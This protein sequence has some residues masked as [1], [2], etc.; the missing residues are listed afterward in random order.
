MDV[1]YIVE[2]N[3]DSVRV[4]AV[5]HRGHKGLMSEVS[6]DATLADIAQEFYE[7]LASIGGVEIEIVEG[8]GVRVQ[9]AKD[10]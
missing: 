4:Y 8:Y 5:N 6:Q 2:R 10:E 3:G 1:K 7:V 9:G